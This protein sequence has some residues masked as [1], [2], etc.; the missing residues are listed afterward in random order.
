MI[1]STPH[2]VLL[3]VRSVGGCS[4]PALVRRGKTPRLLDSVTGVD[5]GV[6][7]SLLGRVTS[8]SP[9][10]HG[11]LANDRG[12]TRSYEQRPLLG[13]ADAGHGGDENTMS[14]LPYTPSL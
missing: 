13:R 11:G 12:S 5:R 10:N 2:H 4:R 8:G 7:R 1:P 3:F 6:G 14:P 9:G